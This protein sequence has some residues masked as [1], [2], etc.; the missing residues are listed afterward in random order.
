[1]NE[2]MRIILSLL[3]GFIVIVM[4]YRINIENRTIILTDKFNKNIND[5][6]KINNKCFKYN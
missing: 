2:N 3:L 5:D 1:M 4:F 6:I